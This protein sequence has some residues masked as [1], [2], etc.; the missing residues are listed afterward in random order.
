MTGKPVS[1]CGRKVDGAGENAQPR[2]PVPDLASLPR[3]YLRGQA[4]GMTLAKLLVF[5]SSRLPVTRLLVCGRFGLTR[6][7]KL[8]PHRLG[9][10]AIP[11]LAPRYNVSPGTE[12][13]VVRERKGTREATLLR[14]G[15]VPWWASDPGIGA[16]MA[17]ARAD[18]AFTKPA[19]RDPMHR[20]RCLIPADVFYEWSG[21]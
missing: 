4:S 12:I 5:A 10:T 6:P 2:P 8:D 9:V 17:N 1:N 19:F 3:Y 21:R 11:G 7:D 13:L 14:W 16:R 15:L 18:S 20:R